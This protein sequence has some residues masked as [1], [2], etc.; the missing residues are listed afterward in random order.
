MVGIFDGKI[1]ITDHKLML[2]G[3][4]SEAEAHYLCGALNSLPVSAAVA[5]YAI[6]IQINTH[7]LDHIHVPRFSHRNPVHKHLASWSR[8]AHAAAHTGNAERLAQAETGIHR[9]AARLWGLSEGDLREMREF[10][11]EAGIEPRL[12]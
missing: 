2:V 6:E 11:R 3:V 4:E 5:A 7:V 12:A 9:W 10:L 1:V 8:K